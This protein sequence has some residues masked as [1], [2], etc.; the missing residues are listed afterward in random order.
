M[1]PPCCFQVPS[2]EGRRIQG[3]EEQLRKL[4]NEV[5]VLQK[6]SPLQGTMVPRLLAY[7]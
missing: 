5:E 1:F 4:R 3:R 7:G 6:L 2:H